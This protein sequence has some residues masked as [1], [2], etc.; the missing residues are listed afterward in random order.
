MK[1]VKLLQDRPEAG[2]VEGDI[3][4]Y[5]ELSA[6]SVIKRGIAEEYDPEADAAADGE[7]AET[8]TYGGQ[9]A[10]TID[11]IVDPGVARQK[12]VM[13]FSVVADTDPGPRKS[14]G[15]TAA[16]AV[17][18]A[19]SADVA[20]AADAAEAEKP[21]AKAS[22]GKA[23]SGGGKSAEVASTANVAGA[24]AGGGDGI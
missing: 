7:A 3:V 21:A 19:E 8:P 13:A 20:G 15:V 4:S 16:E 17:A 6:A 1:Q 14:P 9:P 5:D 18:E 10:A 23:S 11:D 12:G 24:D 2:L 22:R